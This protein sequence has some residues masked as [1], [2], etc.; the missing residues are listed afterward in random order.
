MPSLHDPP[1]DSS[2]DAFVLEPYSQ[3]S[4]LSCYEPDVRSNPDNKPQIIMFR[5]NPFTTHDGVHGRPVP[6]AIRTHCHPQ[7]TE[8]LYFEFQ[9]SIENTHSPTSESKPE[10]DPPSGFSSPG[11]DVTIQP[12]QL[13][14]LDGETAPSAMLAEPHEQFGTT[15]WSSVPLFHPHPQTPRQSFLDNSHR[16]PATFHS[17]SQFDHQ[18]HPFTRVDRTPEPGTISFQRSSNLTYPHSLA[19]YTHYAESESGPMYA[20]GSVSETGQDSPNGYQHG[21]SSSDTSVD[22]AYSATH[23]P[24]VGS[25]FYS[26]GESYNDQAYSQSHSSFSSLFA[27]GNS[28]PQHTLFA[29]PAQMAIP[30]RQ[31]GLYSSVNGNPHP[32]QLQYPGGTLSSTNPHPP[33][34][35]TLSLEH[36]PVD[37]QYASDGARVRDGDRRDMSFAQSN[38]EARDIKFSSSSPHQAPSLMRRLPTTVSYDSH[39]RESYFQNAP[40]GYDQM[41]S[42]GY[43]QSAGGFE[44]SVNGSQYISRPPSS[45]FDRRGSP[46]FE[47][48]VSCTSS[49]ELSPPPS[50]EFSRTSSGAMDL[51]GSSL[52]YPPITHASEHPD[53]DFL[54]RSV[55]RASNLFVRRASH[56]SFHPPGTITPMR[57][58]DSPPPIRSLT[59]SPTPSAASILADQ[60]GN[61]R[62]SRPFAPFPPGGMKQKGSGPKRHA[63]MVCD[64]DF[65]RPSTLRAHMST[66]TGERPHLCPVK[67]CGKRFSVSSNLRRHVKSHDPQGLG[68][69]PH[70]RRKKAAAA[71]KEQPEKPRPR[72]LQERKN[73]QSWCPE[74]LSRMHNAKSLSSRPPFEMPGGIAPAP[75]PL[76]VVRPHGQPGD[77]NYEDRDSFFY[78]R[79]TDQLRP[80]HPDV[81]GMRPTLP[82]PL[83][84][85]VGREVGTRGADGY[86][87]TLSRLGTW[88]GD[89]HQV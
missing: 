3:L 80:Y 81:W 73:V 42:R 57:I 60:G 11:S 63:C 59:V 84:S 6:A 37:R 14:Y 72:P 47:R 17:H 19:R 24:T 46:A 8:P 21:Y 33:G 4:P 9:L 1:L 64:K 76:P 40:R 23:V 83:P 25:H 27:R 43:E 35:P 67:G 26:Q 74:S 77:E 20:P 53:P 52:P 55:S 49:G 68:P 54:H 78:A 28:S 16:S 88:L 5:L 62:A 58:F 12:G 69:V 70:R 89:H 51:A 41:A 44:Q 32:S 61:S 22:C 85:Q 79:N 65:D 13:Q 29:T 39:Q 31:E 45:A 66:H 56:D 30:S 10:D 75:A 82:G 15:T 38:A 50:G 71:H 87:G 34:H 36:L 2:G 48:S 18:D 7:G 86:G